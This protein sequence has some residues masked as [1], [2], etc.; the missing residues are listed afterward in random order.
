MRLLLLCIALVGCAMTPEQQAQAI[1][2]NYGPLCENVGYVKNTEEYGECV[3]RQYHADV[4]IQQQRAAQMGA[5]GMFLLNQSQPRAPVNTT[6]SRLGNFVN[7]TS[8]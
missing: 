2:N 6:C 4:Q 7:C 3:M 1:F 5:T 8:Q